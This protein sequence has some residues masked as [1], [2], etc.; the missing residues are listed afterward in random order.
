M[1]CHTM[2]CCVMLRYCV[3]F[4]FCFKL[5]QIFL[6]RF[7]YYYVIYCV[8]LS[9][10]LLCHVKLCYVLY[11]YV[12]LWLRSS[13]LQKLKFL[14]RLCVICCVILCYVML[15]YVML[16]YCFVLCFFKKLLSLPRNLWFE[17]QI[18]ILYILFC[19]AKL[20]YAFYVMLYTSMLR[21]IVVFYML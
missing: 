18:I 3:V 10:I 4:C 6:V 12:K 7:A 16:Y 1:L 8:L 11:S 14:A 13:F 2:L 17:L 9:F 20:C 19:Y 5:R 21:F 15:R